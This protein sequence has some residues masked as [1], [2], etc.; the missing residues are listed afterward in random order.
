MYDDALQVLYAGVRSIGHNDHLP[1]IGVFAPCCAS[2]WQ[3]TMGESSN[4]PLPAT[5]AAQPFGQR[6]AIGSGARG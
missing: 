3:S 5:R 1:V 2:G 4:Q 6:A